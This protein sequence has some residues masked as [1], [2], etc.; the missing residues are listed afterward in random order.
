MKGKPHCGGTSPVAS[1]T[2]AY[3][4]NSFKYSRKPTANESQKT[5]HM[6]DAN[7][8]AVLQSKA[9]NTTNSPCSSIP[10]NCSVVVWSSEKTEI[11]ISKEQSNHESSQRQKETSFLKCHDINSLSAA[12]GGLTQ[13][14]AQ[15][16]KADVEVSQKVSTDIQDIELSSTVRS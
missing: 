1:T 15:S 3:P 12:S 8:P 14:Q 10:S 16:G 5:P 2:L 11:E 7:S 9:A 13:E 6:L 4:G